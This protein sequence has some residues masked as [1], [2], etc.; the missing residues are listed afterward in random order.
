M[1]HTC[2]SWLVRKGVSLY[3]V[4]HLLGRESFQ[5]TQSYAHLQRD[6]HKPSSTPGSAWR[7]L[8]HCFVAER[9]A[10]SWLGVTYWPRSQCSAALILRPSE[11][12]RRDAHLTLTPRE[13]T[14]Q[15]PKKPPELRFL[16]RHGIAL[17][18][19]DA[20]CGVRGHPGEGG[21]GLL[22]CG[23]ARAHGVRCGGCG[24]CPDAGMTLS[25]ASWRS[26]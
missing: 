10:S 24:R 23:F 3:E 22:N 14:A 21:Q 15:I 25:E 8:G 5:T 9:P 20:S 11:R 18:S 7:P 1:R 4:Q 12:A 26:P 19:G 13:S 17:V 2:A 6:A 16:D